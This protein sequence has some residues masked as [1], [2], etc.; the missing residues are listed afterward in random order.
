MGRDLIE[1]GL[2]PGILFGVL[3]RLADDAQD[4][5]EFTDKESALIWLKEKINLVI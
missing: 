3:L 2:K 1:L 4:N 5:L